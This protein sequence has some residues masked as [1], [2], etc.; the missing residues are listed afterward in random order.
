MLMGL[1][2][3]NYRSIAVSLFC[4]IFLLFHVYDNWFPTIQ[5]DPSD[6]FKHKIFY[7][8]FKI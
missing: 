8:S 2:I 3:C 4:L 1:K 6:T 5:T 7:S